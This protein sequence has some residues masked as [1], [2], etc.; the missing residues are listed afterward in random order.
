MKILHLAPFRKTGNLTDPRKFGMVEGFIEAGHEW[1]YIK[2][3]CTSPG[4]VDTVVNRAKDFDTV[5]VSKG[6]HIPFKSF[7]AITDRCDVTYWTADS[8]SRIPDQ[9]GTLALLCNRVIVTGTEGARWL[10]ENGY[11]KRIAQIYLGCRQYVWKPG[12][13]PR[14]HQDRACFLGTRR[15]T[16]D[17]GRGEKLDA[18]QE[19]GIPILLSAST[20]HENAAAAYWNSAVCLNFVSGDITSD[21]VVRVL[22]SGGF[23]LTER[24]ADIDFSFTGGELATFESENTEHMLEQLRFY[25]DRPD[26]REEIAARGYEWSRSMT[27]K[28]QMD[29]MCRFI[30]G[31]DVL[32]DGAAGEYL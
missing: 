18:I 9:L 12:T 10:R 22:S 6:T 13:L 1:D 31:E 14:A 17:G 21:R 15:Y 30:A 7:Q 19:S 32:P 23:C 25:L 2:E 29:K 26:L 16:R 28:N 11:N 5:F 27:H 20:M 8:I 24:N 4:Y 3:P